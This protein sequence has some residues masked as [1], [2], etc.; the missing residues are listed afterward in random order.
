MNRTDYQAAKAACDNLLAVSVE[1]RAAYMIEGDR[2]HEPTVVA[3]VR[4]SE[5]HFPRTLAMLHRAMELLG[6]AVMANGYDSRERDALLKEWNAVPLEAVIT[7]E[8]ITE[9]LAVMDAEDALINST[10]PAKKPKAR[11]SVKKP[12][13]RRGK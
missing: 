9:E 11:K 8:K 1:I 6:P 4:M 3:F 12:K 5:Q 2:E 10:I 13:T 7:P